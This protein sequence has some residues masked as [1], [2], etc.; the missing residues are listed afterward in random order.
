MIIEELLRYTKNLSLLYVEDNKLIQSVYSD[1]FSS[2]FADIT[3]ANDGVDALE[4]FK[5]KK[6]DN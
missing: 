1:L 6:F 5:N 3:V 4:K 2:L